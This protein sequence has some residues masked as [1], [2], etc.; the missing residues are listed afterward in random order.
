MKVAQA[1]DVQS[2]PGGGSDPPVGK[3]HV[4]AP[5]RMAR[6][7]FLVQPPA[8]GGATQDIRRSDPDGDAGNP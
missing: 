2:L 8:G 6:G 5:R 7:A 1:R 4:A 3:L